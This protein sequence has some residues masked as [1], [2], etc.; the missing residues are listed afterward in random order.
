MRCHR[1]VVHEVERLVLFMALAACAFSPRANAQTTAPDSLPANDSTRYE[2]SPI[3]VTALRYAQPILRVPMAVN[4]MNAEELHVRRGYGMEEALQSVP[5]VLAQTRSGN[6][7]IRITIRGF[8]ARGAGDRSNTGTSRGIRVLVDGMP[9]TEPDGR[10]SFDLIDLT[11]AEGLE[12]IRSNASA[13]WGN[14][15]GGVINISSTPLFE[16]NFLTARTLQGSFGFNKYVLQSGMKL[17]TAKLS[18]AL[19]RNDFIGWRQNS[20][21]ERTLVDVD[22]ISHPS[23]QTRLGVFLIGTYNKFSVPGP[24]SLAQFE[25]DP[26]QANETYLKRSERRM[27]R[28]GR[29]GVTLEHEVDEAHGFS[30]QVFME[31][32]FLQRSE[33]GTFR[34]FTRYHVGG[35][36][37]Y[38]FA[39]DFSP[40]VKSKFQIGMDEAYQDGAILF[41]S[42]SSTNERGSTLRDNKREGANSFGAYVQEDLSLSPALNFVLGL[43]YNDVTYHNESFINDNLEGKKSFRRWTPKIGAAYQLTPMHSVYANWGSGVE[44]PAGNETDPAGTFGQDTVYALNPLLEPIHSNTFELGMKQVLVASQSLLRGLSYDVAAYYISIDN[45]IVPYRAGRFYFTAGKTRRIGAEAGVNAQFEGDLSV[46]A[47]FT[48]LNSRYVNY[49]VD[50]VHYG[51][52]NRFAVYDDNKVAG[53]PNVYYNAALRFAPEQLGNAFAELSVQGVGNYFVDDANVTSVPAYNLLNLTLGLEK[54]LRLAENLSLSGFLG[55]YNL[56]DEKYIS[57]AFINPDIVNGAPL[58]LE[59]GLPRNFVIGLSLSSGRGQ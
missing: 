56:T 57:S 48:Y 46:Q 20:A 39:H 17:G 12:V 6:Q 8:G 19:L 5:G 29:I 23:A 25:A 43:R 59:P 35:N 14:A 1:K 31:P 44:V 32:K 2:I 7:D 22:F 42:L 16:S 45:D 34:D 10:T 50:S 54:P 3:T 49:T 38:R 28:V 18:I 53:I 52:A 24:L 30:G 47:A 11:T 9:T 37:S 27:N 40:S 55:V 4:V 41:Y 33:R 21:S 15:A 51:K 36:A 13:I 58:Y 26:K